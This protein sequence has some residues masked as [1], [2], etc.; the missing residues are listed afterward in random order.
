VQLNRLEKETKLFQAY[1]GNFEASLFHENACKCLLA[2]QPRLK[3][4][5]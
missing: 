5:T 2:R 4:V 3:S 1:V